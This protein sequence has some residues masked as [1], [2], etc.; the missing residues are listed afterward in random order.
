MARWLAAPSPDNF[1]QLRQ[2]LHE[3]KRLFLEELA[4]RLAP[5][6]N[7]RIAELPHATYEQKKELSKWLN[8]ESRELGLTFAC[9]KTGF[10]AFI[11]GNTG[12]DRQVGRFVFHALKQNG[13]RSTSFSAAALPPLKL[14]PAP[15]EGQRTS[16]VDRTRSQDDEG[17][18]SP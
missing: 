8:Q 4:S 16:W 11:T 14:M 13:G 5:A 9:P 7:A 15:T 1:K 10:P 6:L 2:S 17:H 12:S 18:G 3:A